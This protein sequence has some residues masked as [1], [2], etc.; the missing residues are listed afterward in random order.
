MSV[1]RVETGKTQI[2]ADSLQK[3]ARALRTTVAELVA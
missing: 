2:K 3:I 1:W